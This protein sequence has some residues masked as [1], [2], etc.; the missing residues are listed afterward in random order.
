[1]ARIIVA[2]V[3]G[4]VLVS[5]RS[6]IEK[7]SMIEMERRKG[8]RESVVVDACVRGRNLRSCQWLEKM[9]LG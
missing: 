9:V 6:F 5:K 7:R 1:M 4:S 8:S 3:I 2:C